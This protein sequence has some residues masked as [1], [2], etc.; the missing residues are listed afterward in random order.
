VTNGPGATQRARHA[1][2]HGRLADATSAIGIFAGGGTSSLFPPD[3]IPAT[4]AML[5]TD[6]AGNTCSGG[7]F[8]AS[9]T[10]VWNLLRR[11]PT[12]APVLKPTRRHDRPVN[13][14]RTAAALTPQIESG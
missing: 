6:Q 2:L 9:T 14:N 5:Y 10:Y 1:L 11:L 4:D 12:P 7:L 8:P 13:R 3:G